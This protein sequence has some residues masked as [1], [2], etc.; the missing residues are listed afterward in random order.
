MRYVHSEELLPSVAKL[1]ARGGK[2]QKAAQTIYSILGEITAKNPNP[3]DSCGTTNYGE[4]RIKHC[5]KYDLAGAC[6]LVTVCNNDITYLL[7]AGNHDEVDRWIERH[8][9][10]EFI[11]NDRNQLVTTLKPSEV[12]ES[13]D[14]RTPFAKEFDAAILLVERLSADCRAMLLDCVNGSIAL[15]LNELTVLS[16]EE[17]FLEICEKISDSG[18][19]DAVLDVLVAL[20]ANDI[21]EA[22]SRLRLLIGEYKEVDDSELVKEGKNLKFIPTDSPEWVTLFQHFARTS[23]YK[24]WMLFLHPDQA[25]SVDENFNG[26]SKLLGVSGS[27]KT[28]VVVKRA[29]RLA[30]TYPGEQIIIL[31][32]NPALAKLIDELVT[33]AADSV[34]R[35]AV[36][37]IPFFE[38]CQELIYEFEPGSERYYSDVT[39]KSE[40]HIDAVWREFYRCDLNNNEAAVMQP[41]HDSL[42]SQRIDS[43]TYIREEF[44][45]IR[46]A[47][48]HNDRSKYLEL[49]RTGRS[50]PLQ[51]QQRELILAGLAAWERKMKSVGVIDGLGLVAAMQPYLEK[52]VPRYRSILVD[53]SQDFG[54]S[55]LE[56]IRR[57]VAP[58]ENDIFICGDAAQQI[59]SKHQKY[60]Q[61]G[62]DVPGARSRRLLKNYRNSKEILTA[63]YE[64]LTKNINEFHIDS[65]EFEVLDPVF[66]DFHGPTPL[67]LSAESYEGEI[68]NALTFAKHEVESNS[69]WK[70]CVAFAGQSLYE[71][72]AFARSLKIPL[73]DGSRSI[74]E[75]AVYFSDLAQTKGFEFDVMIVVNV[76]EGV[77][78]NPNVPEMEQAKDL[79]QLYV[80]MTRAKNQLVLSYHGRPSPLVSGVE[81][82]LLVDEW[83]SYNEGMVEMLGVPPKLSDLDIDSL[84]PENIAQLDGVQFL[85]TEHAIGLPMRL[86]ENIR[87]KIGHSDP[88]AGITRMAVDIGFAHQQTIDNPRARVTF[89]PEA[90]KDLQ[91]LGLRIGLSK[92]HR[93]RL[94]SQ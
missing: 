2:F 88:R 58:D 13:E 72:Q 29:I 70:A 93:Q 56:I 62:I 46:S 79:A 12:L 89:G 38:L 20:A 67:L 74:D 10:K 83:V 4:K 25:A 76:C 24:E 6:R 37:V 8:R 65:E 86:I 84:I 64:V 54:T 40:E 42:I 31:T 34:A 44:D 15:K 59:S 85:Y 90:S 68:A 75:H 63:A 81:E 3:F 18:V 55:E 14:E 32:L 33:E 82:V 43:E 16:E 5:T 21:A 19:S 49:E 53:E 7:F 27:G 48:A 91:E 80:A 9:G 26:P 22:E 92:L 73:L 1:Q 50:F 87:A 69:S 28:C 45:W 51:R 35:Q 61:A 41:V 57:L 52:L 66:A 17:Q 94:S 77:L 30:Q 11:V 60:R 23:G 36:R 39:W 71:I 47:I 78:P